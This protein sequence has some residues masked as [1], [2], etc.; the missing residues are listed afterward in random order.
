M[1]VFHNIF[2]WFWAFVC[3]HFQSFANYFPIKRD[4]LG[5]D[6]APG[7]R[8]GCCRKCLSQTISKSYRSM[9]KYQLSESNRLN[10]CILLS[11]SLRSFCQL[12]SDSSL[13]CRAPHQFQIGSILNAIYMQRIMQNVIHFIKITFNFFCFSQVQFV[14]QIHDIVIES[15]FNINELRLLLKFIS[16]YLSSR[17]WLLSN[18]SS[19]KEKCIQ[20]IEMKF[21][22]KI[23]KIYQLRYA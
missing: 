8:T 21:N 9:A 19:H 6:L 5:I 13:L 10:A 20:E 1:N 22:K 2:C 3:R 4:K 11:C 18:N 7:R 16:I 17:N 23:T 12:Y 15:Y 14:L